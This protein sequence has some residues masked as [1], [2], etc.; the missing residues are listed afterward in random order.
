MLINLHHS[1][2]EQHTYCL[3]LGYNMNK[4]KYSPHD[5]GYFLKWSYPFISWAHYAIINLVLWYL[6]L[7]R[8]VKCHH[9]EHYAQCNVFHQHTLLFRHTLFFKMVYLKIYCS[10][11]FILWHRR[12]H[13]LY[14]LY[15]T[16]WSYMVTWY[17]IVLCLSHTQ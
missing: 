15:Y 1:K 13:S 2:Y 5:P 4:F 17:I 9:E 16:S 7:S 11:T 8:K 14:K 3:G 12:D 10:T 6:M